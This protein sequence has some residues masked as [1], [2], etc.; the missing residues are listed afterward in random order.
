MLEMRHAAFKLQK[1]EKKKNNR[2]FERDGRDIS[3]GADMQHGAISFPPF[4]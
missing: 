4:T 2:L 3:Y 1:E